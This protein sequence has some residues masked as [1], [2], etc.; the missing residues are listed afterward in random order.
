MP[1]NEREFAVN[2]IATY[3]KIRPIVQFGD[4]YRLNSPYGSDGW[5]SQAFVSP[6]KNRAL[7]FAY[8]VKHHSAGIFPRIKLKGLDAK[9]T[10]RLVEL[11]AK[12]KPM[13]LMN[14]SGDI[15]MKVGIDLP[16]RLQYESIVLQ[17]SAIEQTTT[18]N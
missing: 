16:I 12:E 2:A 14:I 11:N 15:L 8:S 13:A 4:L 10:Y 6:G 9:K 18:A 5:A 3:K 17:L 7:L 1:K